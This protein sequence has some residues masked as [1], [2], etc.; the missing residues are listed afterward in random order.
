MA[1]LKGS[2]QATAAIVEEFN[3]R[4]FRRTGGDYIYFVELVTH[5]Q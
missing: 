1:E 3:E 2:R 5:V 4:E